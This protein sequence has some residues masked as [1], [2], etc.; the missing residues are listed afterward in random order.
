MGIIGLAVAGVSLGGA[1]V[2]YLTSQKF[3]DLQAYVKRVSSIDKDNIEELRAMAA[4]QRERKD[5]HSLAQHLAGPAPPG[6]S[7]VARQSVQAQPVPAEEGIDPESLRRLEQQAADKV[8]E[9]FT[10]PAE[11]SEMATSSGLDA[12]GKEWW[13]RELASVAVVGYRD[14]MGNV[15]YLWMDMSPNPDDVAKR[16]LAFEDEEDAGAILRVLRNIAREQGLVLPEDTGTSG[17]FHCVVRPENVRVLE[18]KSQMHAFVFRK[19]E[20]QMWMGMNE[21]EVRLAAA[22]VAAACPERLGASKPPPPPFPEQE[23]P[24]NIVR[25]EGAAPGPTPVEVAPSGHNGVAATKVE[26]EVM[27]PEGTRRRAPY[28]DQVLGRSGKGA[29]RAKRGID[30]SQQWWAE[31]GQ[32]YMIQYNFEGGKSGLFVCD[33]VPMDQP[34]SNMHIVAFQDEGAAEAVAGLSRTWEESAGAIS[35][36]VTACTPVQLAGIAEENSTGVT[37]MRGAD[38][39]QLRPGMTSADMSMIVARAAA[40]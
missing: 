30:L 21:E 3:R 35:S 12:S 26:V 5:S 18:M 13:E 2:Y 17:H 7:G 32:L 23:V 28:M 40:L 37:V 10:L 9:K 27:P 25:S 24:V 14:D 33:V 39:A 15:E 1:L 22:Q 36:G 19:R 20:M 31:A 11:A 6:S 29:Q 8:R 38:L 16:F 34:G 4:E